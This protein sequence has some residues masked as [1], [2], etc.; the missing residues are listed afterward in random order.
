ME[1]EWVWGR[2]SSDDKGGLIGILSALESLIS[3]EFE[4]SR[5]IV[6]AFGFDEE[7][8]GTH[9]SHSAHARSSHLRVNNRSGSLCSF[10]GD[11]R[12]LWNRLFCHDS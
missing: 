3:H 6:L 8:S 7:A 11:V 10:P 2:G 9:V 12:H 4:P 5:S 1:G